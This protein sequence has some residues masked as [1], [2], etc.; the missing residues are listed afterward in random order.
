MQADLD[1]SQAWTQDVCCS[2]DQL[3]LSHTAQRE[4]TLRQPLY[5]N[6]AHDAWVQA[7]CLLEACIHDTAGGTQVTSTVH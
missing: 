5:Q 7:A 4:L 2:T 1:D 6:H 3:V